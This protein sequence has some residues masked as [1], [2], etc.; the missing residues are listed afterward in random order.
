MNKIHEQELEIFGELYTEFGT[1]RLLKLFPNA[2]DVP[3]A[4]RERGFLSFYV[5]DNDGFA[6]NIYV[7]CANIIIKPYLDKPKH[8]VHF[9]IEDEN[10]KVESLDV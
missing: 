5:V 7:N 1:F 8:L 6:K 2:Y 3:S 9:L 4:L 10:I